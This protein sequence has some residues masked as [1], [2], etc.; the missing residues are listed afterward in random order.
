ML[1]FEFGQDRL[2]KAHAL[3]AF[4]LNC[5]RPFGRTQTLRV[6]VNVLL[7]EDVPE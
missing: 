5:A 3:K 7:P 1:Y 6:L 4:G 2:A